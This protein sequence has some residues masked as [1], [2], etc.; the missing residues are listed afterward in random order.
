MVEEEVREFPVLVQLKGALEGEFVMVA[1]GADPELLLQDAGAVFEFP[2]G[3]NVL[4]EEGSAVLFVVVA[5][6]AYARR[7]SLSPSMGSEG[8]GLAEGVAQGL[9]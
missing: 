3:A 4:I 5:S 9:A 7:G 8:P 6:A 1:D 2:P